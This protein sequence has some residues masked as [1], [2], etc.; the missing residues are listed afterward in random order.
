MTNLV[1]FRS[2]AEGKNLRCHAF[3]TASQTATVSFCQSAMY[4]GSVCPAT[5]NGIRGRQEP[6][7]RAGLHQF[8]FLT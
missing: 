6:K 5:D 2:P 1:Y 7:R 4:T 8:I 3:P